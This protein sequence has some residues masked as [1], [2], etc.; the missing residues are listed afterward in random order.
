M[1]PE[2]FNQKLARARTRV[3]LKLRSARNLASARAIYLASRHDRQLRRDLLYL[4]AE[5]AVGL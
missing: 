4:G 5:A 3:G 1:K 2:E